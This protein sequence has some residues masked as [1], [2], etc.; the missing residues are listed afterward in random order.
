M[1]AIVASM[2]V[3]DLCPLEL[4]YAPSFGAAKDIVNIAGFAACNRRDSL[5]VHTSQLLDDP[6]ETN[7]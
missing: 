6:I 2:T 5:V 4:V 1:T 3:E 7:C